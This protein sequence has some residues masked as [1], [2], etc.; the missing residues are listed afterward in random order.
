[1]HSI[2]PWA[3]AQTFSSSSYYEIFGEVPAIFSFWLLKKGRLL[4]YHVIIGCKTLMKQFSKL[5]FCFSSSRQVS[6]THTLILWNSTFIIY[7]P[8]HHFI[9][10]FRG[11][12][13]NILF[14][15][16]KNVLWNDGKE[17][18]L[19]CYLIK[20]W[21]NF[22]RFLFLSTNFSFF[23]RNSPIAFYGPLST[24]SNWSDGIKEH[25]CWNNKR[26]ANIREIGTLA[27][28]NHISNI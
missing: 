2:W 15:N 10:S 19:I 16:K 5:P 24:K 17:F 1:M 9:V 22:K 14:P 28:E 4:F 7:F 11:F 8:S 18:N 27:P 12:H 25:I 20:I 21:E 13:P 6:M 23:L 26:R 3:F